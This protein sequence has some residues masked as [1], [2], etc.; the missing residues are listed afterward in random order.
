MINVKKGLFVKIRTLV[1]EGV[2]RG[3]QRG[4]FF[5]GTVAPTLS[6]PGYLVPWVITFLC[7]K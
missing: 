3:V 4:V 7:S 5:G 1:L 6:A 2:G